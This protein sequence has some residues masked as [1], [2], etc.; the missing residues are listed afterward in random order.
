MSLFIGK[1]TVCE[2]MGTER[3][4]FDEV[5]VISSENSWNKGSG[6]P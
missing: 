5:H 1:P 3:T 6:N 4:L 2:V